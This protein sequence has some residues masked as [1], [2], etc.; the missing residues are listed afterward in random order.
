MRARYRL[1]YFTLAPL[2]PPFSPF[3]LRCVS[4]PLRRSTR[5]A[6]DRPVVPRRVCW[7]RALLYSNGT[8]TRIPSGEKTEK[9]GAVARANRLPLARHRSPS[10]TSARFLGSS[11]RVPR[12]VREYRYLARVKENVGNFHA[13]AHQGAGQCARLS[14]G[15]VAWLAKLARA[16]VPSRAASDQRSNGIP[17]T[18]ATAKGLLLES[19]MSRGGRSTVYLHPLLPQR[20]IRR[21]ARCATV[22]F[23][24]RTE[25][26]ACFFRPC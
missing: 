8:C 5:V 16:L 2:S 18:R 7:S 12:H 3:L 9:P 22:K 13:G 20:E 11:G 14:R 24:A 25:A 1:Y 21:R 23:N 17:F 26:L 19:R 15:G 10:R 6:L 4:T